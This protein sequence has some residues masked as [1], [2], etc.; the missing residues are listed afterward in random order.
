MAPLPENL[1]CKQRKEM[2][3]IEYPTGGQAAKK[4]IASR[5]GILACL[6]WNL[7]CC[8]GTL[9]QMFAHGDQGE[10]PPKQVNGQDGML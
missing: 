9:V 5:G 2:G 4:G 3:A 1:T 7:G 8:F 10:A 6:N